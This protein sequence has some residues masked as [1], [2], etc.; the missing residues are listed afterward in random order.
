MGFS[1][2]VSTNELSRHLDDPNWVIVDCR[3]SLSDTERGRQDYRTTH[4]PGSVYAHLDEDL[5]AP[6]VL[7]ETGRHPLPTIDKLVEKF[8]IWGI[9]PGVQVVVYD[10][11]SQASGAIAARLWWSLRFLG[12]DLVAVLDGGWQQWVSERKSI[13]SGVET[14]SRCEFLPSLRPELLVGPQDIEIMRRDPLYKVFDSRTS[15]R[16]RGENETIDLVA[17]HI[18]GAF[19]APYNSTIGPEGRFLPPEALRKHFLDLFG[20]VPAERTVFYCGS[21]VT[22]AHNLVA[23]A[24]SGLGEAPLYVG[25]WS[26]WI[27]DPGR[28]VATGSDTG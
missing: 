28:P 22:A 5:C 13:T 6:A 1:S 19:S 2:I 3:F 25:S 21:G 8:S 17:G 18:P 9:C 16:Y 15:D 10:D 11:W 26:E 24:H 7:G 23:L 12:H 14:N 20:D 4:I 27:T